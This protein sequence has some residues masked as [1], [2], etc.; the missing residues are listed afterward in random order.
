[1]II[2]SENP[3]YSLLNAEIYKAPKHDCYFVRLPK[4]AGTYTKHILVRHG[5][6]LVQHQMLP[7]DFATKSKKIIPIR[8]PIDRYIAGIGQDYFLGHL[9]CDFSDDA[10]IENIFNTISYSPHTGRQVDM[11]NGFDT[12]SCTFFDVDVDYTKNIFNYLLTNFDI[13]IPYNN[14]YKNANKN[15]SDEDDSKKYAKEKI[16]RLLEESAYLEKIKQYFKSDIDF[17]CTVLK[18]L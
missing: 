10:D 18:P 9:K 6:N 4:N 3:R 5:W 15:A 17:Y 16:S 14:Y 11:L 1:M 2:R 13:F 12:E 7:L 8:E